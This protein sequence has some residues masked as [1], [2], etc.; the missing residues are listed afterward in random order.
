[1]LEIARTA[2]QAHSFEEAADYLFEKLHYQ[3]SQSF[4]WK[5]TNFVG[6]VILD[7]RN[8]R[9]NRL[10]EAIM[11]GDL[12]DIIPALYPNCKKVDILYSL[13]DGSFVNTRSTTASKNFENTSNWRECKMCMTFRPEDLIKRHTKKST[14]ERYTI[15][16]SDYAAYI[17]RKDDFKYVF[18]DLMLQNGT[19]KGST[20]VL[21][22]DGADW[23]YNM[24]LDMLK[25]IGVTIV[26]INDLFHTKQNIGKFCQ[27]VNDVAK[28]RGEEPLL[29]AD[30]LIAQT[31]G[32]MGT[33]VPD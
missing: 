30:N 17:G 14:E 23:I 24:V 3:F 32:N 22:S 31:P 1:M 9:I 2:I 33:R 18:L 29:S 7:E 4:V 6:F 11:S 25:P 13:I 15:G 26:A 5:I 21:I 20:V 16:K 12:N 8:R 27:S 19:R 28:A 10:V